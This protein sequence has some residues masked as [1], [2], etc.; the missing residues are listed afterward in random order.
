MMIEM[1][2]RLAHSNHVLSGEARMMTFNMVRGMFD[3]T[4]RDLCFGG[5]A[6]WEQD[7]HNV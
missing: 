5:Y 7:S 1:M 2:S 3:V 6:P 4:R